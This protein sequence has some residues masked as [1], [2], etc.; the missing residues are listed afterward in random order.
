PQAT[1]VIESEP[2]PLPVSTITEATS[3]RGATSTTDLIAET[4]PIDPHRQ[5]LHTDKVTIDQAQV[6]SF[7]FRNYQLSYEEQ[8]AVAKEIQKLLQTST[9]APAAL[10]VNSAH[11]TTPVAPVIAPE[12]TITLAVAPIDCF[13]PQSSSPSQEHQHSSPVEKVTSH[14]I[15]FV[16]PDLD[17]APTNSC[18]IIA[19]G[20]EES[21]PISSAVTKSPGFKEDSSPV[22]HTQS[23]QPQQFPR[24]DS[25]A[26]KS[27]DSTTP[28]E[29]TTIY[30]TSARMDAKQEPSRK[31]E[32]D[33]VNRQ[34]AHRTTVPFA[35]TPPAAVTT[36]LSV[37]ANHRLYHALSSPIY[38]FLCF[39]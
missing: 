18:S 27:S 10:A 12:A 9:A 1:V 28:P 6:K 16:E 11:E 30:G 21:S 23:E 24:I 36:G 37:I 19:P 29:K 34:Q 13:K 14:D 38:Y 26:Q 20:V 22:V 25:I 4:T 32:L 33:K 35:K 7:L 31:D 2:S 15:S 17:D 39:T 8:I 3:T 5:K